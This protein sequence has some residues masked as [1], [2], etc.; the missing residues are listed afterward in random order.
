MNDGTITGASWVPGHSGT[1]LSFNGS[2]D[3]VDC[4]TE[5]NANTA[6]TVSAWI[7]VTNGNKYQAIYFKTDGGSWA[8]IVQ[9]R[10]EV[11]NRLYFLVTRTDDVRNIAFDAGSGIP[12][13]QWKHVVGVF[14]GSYLT[15]YVD[16]VPGTP[17][18]LSGTLKQVT[19]KTWIGIR[20]RD[21]YGKDIPFDGIIDEVQVFNRALS[22]SEVTALYTT[23]KAAVRN[24]LIA[25]WLFDEGAGTIAHDSS[26]RIYA[27][28]LGITNNAA[29]ILITGTNALELPTQLLPFPHAYSDLGHGNILFQ[30]TTTPQPP[31][32]QFLDG[33]YT[34]LFLVMVQD[35]SY[36]SNFAPILATDHGL[37][38]EKDIQTYGALFCTSDPWKSY[39][40]G[41]ILL[42][43]GMSGSTNPPRISLIDSDLSYGT[44][45]FFPEPGTPGLCINRPDMTPSGLYRFDGDRNDWVYAGPLCNGHFDT[46]Y[47]TKADGST[48]ANL[49]LGNTY[50]NDYYSSSGGENATFH[51]NV[52]GNANYANTAG[53]TNYAANAGIAV[54]ANYAA[55]ANYAN[56]AGYANPYAHTHPASDVTS[57]TFAESLI[58]HQFTSNV[59]II[60]TLNVANL[61]ATNAPNPN[62]ITTYSDIAPPLP[63]HYNI[64]NTTNY[65]GSVWANFLKYHTTCTSFDSIDDLAILKKIKTVSDEDGK[66]IL[67][68]EA[69]AHLKD[70]HGFYDMAKMDGWHISVQKRLLERIEMLE[71]HLSQLQDTGEK[72]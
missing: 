47:I 27:D 49:K 43:H 5:V 53:S 69:L 12:V 1:A 13:G 66:E 42:G 11:S 67:D 31:Q 21:T 7:K 59:T 38:V 9:L 4:G 19:S 46:L 68:P 8:G 28:S 40:G 15:A 29:Q 18:A 26:N 17:A 52:T 10:I 55:S 23:G 48:L 50:C 57:G 2:T 34:S 71:K 45:G 36:P 16:G 58:P 62:I 30:D 63:D 56:S 32:H 44:F 37:W 41:A 3:Y 51:G 61:Q 64:G 25:E 39:G 20:D 6:I 22:Q 14:D 24:G 33:Q 60:T 35:P 65:F 70:E 72:A 54:S